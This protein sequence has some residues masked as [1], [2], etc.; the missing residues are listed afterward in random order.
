MIECLEIENFKS[1][2]S[3]KLCLKKFNLFTGT[4]SSGKSSII[5]SILTLSQNIEDDKYGLNGP[6]V[7]VGNYRDVK[8][9]NIS[10]G[11]IRIK[12]KSSEDF[13]EIKINESEELSSNRSEVKINNSNS[14]KETKFINY[15]NGNLQY[16]S[17]NRIG[18][19]DIYQKNR[20]LINGVG[21][22]GE[23]AIDYL[24]RHN[25]DVLEENLVLFKE[26]YT[27]MAQ[28]NYWLNEIIGADI[29]VEEI[30]GTDSVKASYGMGN[31]RYSRPRNVGSGISYLISII[32]MCLG[33][34]ENSTLII[35]NPEIHL[36]PRSQSKLCEF[37]YY[38]SMSGRQ[39]I[40]ETH[41]DHIFNAVR[42]GIATQN[43]ESDS[44]VVNF[45][46]LGEEG[47]T[48]N[49]EIEIGQYGAIVN[50]LP[51]LFDQF[52]LDLDKMLGI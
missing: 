45:L 20:S 25:N 22:E 41:S 9:Y 33:S 52:Q 32:V 2:D 46:N 39:I 12:A 4:N 37:L 19:K 35:E 48:K 1:I 36:H 27:L 14:T 15:R 31:G 40:V 42:V 18:S 17:C 44:V 43:M 29:K 50:P 30:A 7:S 28:V 3:L 38:V 10:K 23:Y 26:D 51:E 47:C 6:L 49:N 16:L 11:E 13:V 34:K 5:Q 24:A 21:I 8:N